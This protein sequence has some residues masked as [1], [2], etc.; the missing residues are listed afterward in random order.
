MYLCVLVCR[1]I[2][3]VREREGGKRVIR[4][5]KERGRKREGDERKRER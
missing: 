1:F 4:R 3:E 2:E 5:N